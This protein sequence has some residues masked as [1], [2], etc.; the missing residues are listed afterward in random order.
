MKI[1][2]CAPA[3]VGKTE[4]LDRITKSKFQTDY[5]LTVG[6]DIR[7]I[8]IELENEVYVLSVWDL[9]CT[10]RFEFVRSTFYK[11]ADG[12]IL[13]FDPEQPDTWNGLIEWR[14]ELYQHAGQIPF[15]LVANK[16]ELIEEHEND[17]EANF[18]REYANSENG[19]YVQVD[20]QNYYAL[21]KGLEELVQKIIVS[22][23][24]VNK[25]KKK[26]PG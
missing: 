3:G 11:N 23:A 19:I 9:G 2:V 10:D 16:S 13:I 12:A 15:L 4:L 26:H 6:V 5:K 20:M 24:W 18:P 22:D 7:T 17:T 25:F 1:V 8:D 21:T 14:K